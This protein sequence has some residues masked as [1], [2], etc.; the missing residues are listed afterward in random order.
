MGTGYTRADVSNNIADGNIISASDIDNEYDAIEAAFNSS[1]GHT[2]DGTAAEG[3]AI[4][5]VG[6]VQDLVVS[7]TEV[8]PKTT[9][10]LDL[11][12]S[13]LLY[14]DAYLQGNMYFRDTAL[15]IVS[16]AD[17]QLDIDADVE[18]EL[19]APTVDIDASTALT[20]DTA[21][22]TFTSTVF[23]VTGSA[24]ITGDLDVDN[25]NINGNTIISTDTNGA[26]NVTPNG[27]GAVNITATTNITGDLDVDNIN[28]DGNTIISTDT[29]GN[30][31]LTPNGTGEVDISKVDIAS[32]EI[33]G[34]TI[35]A[36][37]AAAITGT[38]IT[39]TSFVTS[40][41]MTFGD[42]DKAVFGAGSDLQIYHDAS[43]SI[44]NDNGTGSL[45]LQTG[46]NTKVE[47]T[48]GGIDVTG[49]VTAD[50]ASL[51]GAVVINE[52]GADVDFR[53]ESDTNQHMLFVDAGNDRVGIGADS[54]NTSLQVSGNTFIGVNTVAGMGPQTGLSVV[55]G[56]T[57]NDNDAGVL[58]LG[59]HSNNRTT[60][61][62]IGKVDFY[63]NDASGGASGVQSSIRGVTEASIG[64]SAGLRL[65]TGTSSSLLERLR[66]ANNGDISFYD[67]TGVTQGLFWDAS[68]QRLG[69]GS[70]SPSF[71]LEVNA[72]NGG[73]LSVVGASDTNSGW[74][75]KPLGNDLYISQNGISDNVVF[76]DGGNVGI[77][78]T[79]PSS[80]GLHVNKASGSSGLRVQSGSSAGD[81]VQSGT[82][83]FVSNNASGSTL[84]Y[85]NG[86]ERMR[87]TSGGNV[88]I[89]TSSPATRLS[90]GDSTVNSGNVMT[91]GKRVTSAQSN[92]P[93]IGHT[94]H[95]GTASDLGICAT[96]SGGNVIFYTGN[97]AAG[98][99]TGSNTERMRID[100]S[101]NVGIGTGSP[102]TTLHVSGNITANNYIL[103][104]SAATIGTVSDTSIEMRTSADGTPAMI[105]RAN[106]SSERMRIDSSGNL[107]VGRTS[108]LTSQVES[109]SSDSVVS[110]HGTLTAHQT[111]A[112]IM[113]YTSNEMLL[114]SYGATAGTG[115]IVFKTGGGGGS[116]DSEAMRIGANGHLYA[117][118]N[119][120]S[121][122]NLTLRN[123]ASGNTP[124]F[125][126]CR[127]SANNAELVIEPDGDVK[128]ANNVYGALSDAKLKENIINAPS[129]WDDIKA[130]Q[131]RKYNLIGNEQV[132]IGVVAQE[133]EAAGM[134]GL[135]SERIDFDEDGND[136]G[137]TTKS[138]KYSILHTKALKALQ[139]AMERIEELEA[140]IA[141]LEAN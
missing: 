16:S 103:A 2:H 130:L 91:F 131:I 39:G 38:T 66:I 6:P 51:D 63:S 12:T 99:G 95:D 127:D 58:T 61:D 26:I 8:K 27:T 81:F 115:Q 123:G 48:S 105:F 132:H 34:T 29:N 90:I 102:S 88:G 37:S 20:V 64:S 67:S 128:N 43:D 49:T 59:S 7:A 32:G 65:Y 62:I 124:D 42:N 52:S 79:S 109:I 97:D 110:A 87:I 60:N 96:S 89:G 28:I 98:F 5:V 129:Q 22:T 104:P 33:D 21:S 120:G 45:K 80:F 106:G 108:R 137:T 57:V 113:Q 82:S 71:A 140:R 117:T 35:G 40:G 139:E 11:G 31:A 76:K 84:F 114:R 23:N 69:L 18:L 3:G 121:L 17:G 13:A 94:S 68:T 125:L 15:K 107:L 50:G 101:G 138:V 93:V 92:L 85:T 134:S 83:L 36:N 75:L 116:A 44:I 118:C 56:A 73:G 30:I 122:A 119:D 77:G 25:I 133:L 78:T 100:S 4:T 111:N 10:T 53:V 19:V 135:V 112:A 86:S 141:A 55:G 72:A 1:T 54:P 47:V 126:Q 41:D 24:N 74:R 9:N 14:K 46:G 70:T 136:L